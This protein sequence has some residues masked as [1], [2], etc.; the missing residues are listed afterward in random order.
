MVLSVVGSALCRPPWRQTRQVRAG[1]PTLRKGME[2][3]L[4]WGKAIFLFG[5]HL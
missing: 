3:A 4:P 5:E 2:G 1:D